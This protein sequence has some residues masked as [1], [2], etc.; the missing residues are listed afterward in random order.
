MP[1]LLSLQLPGVTRYDTDHTSNEKMTL[2]EKWGRVRKKL[3]TKNREAPGLA[4]DTNMNVY[5]IAVS[6]FASSRR[7]ADVEISS[8]RCSNS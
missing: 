5:K 6:I 8:K 7:E 1:S 3:K 2:N 4:P